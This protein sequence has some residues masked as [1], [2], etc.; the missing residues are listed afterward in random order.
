[1]TLGEL[2]KDTEGLDIARV[3]LEDPNL[4]PL[5]RLLAVHKYGVAGTE[6]TLNV[7]SGRVIPRAVVSTILD[8]GSYSAFVAIGAAKAVDT[9]IGKLMSD[10]DKTLS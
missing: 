2:A 10:D 6:A 1:H 9:E 3:N 8:I 5:Q 7:T 4:A